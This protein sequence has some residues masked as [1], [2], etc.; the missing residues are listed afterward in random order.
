MATQR[1]GAIVGEIALLEKGAKRMATVRTSAYT[2]L[3]V[4]DK[5][6]FLDLDKA[7]MK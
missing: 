1:P 7:M 6:S 4:L 5:K 2:E 3:L